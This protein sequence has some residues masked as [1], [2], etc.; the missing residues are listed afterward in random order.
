MSPAAATHADGFIALDACHHKTVSMLHDLS[1]LLLDLEWKGSSPRMRR[2]AATIAEFFSTTVREHHED[3]ERHVFPRLVDGS[4]KLVRVVLR[5]QEEHDLLEEAWLDIAPH[6]AAIA[7]GS[8]LYDV[9]AL[10]DGVWALV[11]KYQ[12]HIQLEEGILFPAAKARMS[13]AARR[14]MGRLMARTLA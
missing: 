4:P 2:R 11:A 3:E 1:D 7:A 8:P 12:D 13:M 6:V 9:A 10:H 14:T 5:L